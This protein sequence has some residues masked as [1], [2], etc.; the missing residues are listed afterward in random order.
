MGIASLRAFRWWIPGLCSVICLLNF[1]PQDLNAQVAATWTPELTLTVK[2]VPAGSPQWSPNGRWIAF[3]TAREGHANVWRLGLAGGEA[4]QMT[5]EKG[6]ISA[7]EWSPDGSALAF[8]MADPRSDEEEKAA[9]EKRDWRT[10]DQ[11]LKM[12]RLYVQPVSG[13]TNER[14]GAQRLTS[15][16]YSVE[17]FDWAPDGRSIVFQHQPTPSEND[18]THSDISIVAVNDATITPL[19]ISSAAERSPRFSPDGRSVAFE[20]SEPVPAWPATQIVQIVPVAGCTPR[21]LAA[22]YDSLAEIL[23]WTADGRAVVVSE[24]RR[25][26]P[27]LYLVP[28]DGKAPVSVSPSGLNITA[29]A[30]NTRSTHVGFVSQA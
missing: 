17:E 2:R 10:I 12:R 6:G 16:N 21:E 18:W 30:L 1:P 25:T 11:N 26:V 24:T 20:A 19:V 14:R 27:T 29:P 7:F 23:G 4:E 28:L 3:I 5:Q 22:T 8:I 9:K 15:G 13:P